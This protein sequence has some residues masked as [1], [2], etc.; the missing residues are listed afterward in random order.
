MIE[1]LEKAYEVLKDFVWPLIT[2]FV[3]IYLGQ[4]GNI[5]LAKRAE[6]NALAKDIYFALKNQ[7]ESNQLSSVALKADEV[8][9]YIPFWKKHFF[10][11]YVNEYERYY[12]KLSAYDPST[13]IVVRHEVE[14]EKQ[15]NAAKKLLP[16]F[17]PR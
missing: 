11:T 14:I 5:Q 17:K 7:I 1:E 12:N 13:G 10:R 16:Y 9:C 6:F 2:L 3:G 8:E 4:R 15:I